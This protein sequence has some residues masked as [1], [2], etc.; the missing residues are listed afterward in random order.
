VRETTLAIPLGGIAMRRD[1]L[2]I[3]FDRPDVIA[4]I[5]YG[6]VRLADLLRNSTGTPSLRRGNAILH[7]PA[8]DA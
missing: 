5:G 1:L 6:R 2:E 8:D 4:E 3:G 7:R